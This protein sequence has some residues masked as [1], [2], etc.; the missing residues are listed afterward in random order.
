MNGPL[1]IKHDMV[2]MQRPY[3]PQQ[4]QI[5]NL[6]REWGVPLWID[7]DD[8]FFSVPSYNP[9]ATTFNEPQA[10]SCTA[11]LVQMADVISVTTPFLRDKLLK[12]KPDADIRVIPNAFDDYGP[13]LKR[14]G[15]KKQRPG[16]IAWRGGISHA[17]DRATIT[18]AIQQLAVETD[19]QY[20]FFGA[21]P[22]EW[23]EHLPHDSYQHFPIDT[24]MRFNQNLQ[25]QAPQ[26]GIVPLVYNEF[27]QAKS[28]CVAL[29]FLYGGACVLAPADFLEFDHPGCIRYRNDGE[30]VKFLVKQIRSGEIDAQKEADRGWEWVM[31]TRRLSKVNAA[32]AAIIHQYVDQSRKHHV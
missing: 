7:W 31:D 17:G 27:N 20:R 2:F 26:I 9:A 4:I 28:N 14:R 22:F 6:A 32:R 30:A 15:P 3:L 5:A 21:I 12:L 8:D 11:Q 18:E 1:M 13:L 24:F 19:V 10:L 23:I 25:I 29:E 16:V